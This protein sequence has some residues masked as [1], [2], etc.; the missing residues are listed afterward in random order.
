M[1]K[2]D[3]IMLIMNNAAALGAF[4]KV[5]EYYGEDPEPI[6]VKLGIDP[7]LAENPTSR[8]PYQQIEALWIETL[9]LIDDPYI[10]L[11]V[12]KLWHPST[13]GALGYAWLA[14]PTLRAGFERVVRYLQILTDGWSYHI[15]EQGSEFSLI[16]SCY[17]DSLNIP[18]QMDAHLATLIV[19]CR[20]NYGQNLNPISV[21]FTHTAPK[22]TG[23]YFSFFR[24]PV[25]FNAPDNRIT[26][27]REVVDQH[28]PSSNPLLAQ[29]N[30]QIIQDYLEKIGKASTEARVKTEII[31]QLP[32]GK[33]SDSS[34]A[35]ALSLS[36]RTLHR[37]LQTEQTTFGAIMNTLRQELAQ[38]YI[39]DSHLSLSE[40]SFLL[41]FSEVSSFSRAFKRWT[42]S[43]PSVLRKKALLT[44]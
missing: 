6:F 15:E 11:T 16:H 44:G 4:L 10:G 42:G 8:I 41:G 37:R 14:S 12:A 35:E 2:V 28:L 26:L 38:Q 19:L 29:L 25:T 22:K 3:N 27:A 30:D 39:Q 34:I 20:M 5:I 1:N 9:A 24:C 31:H 33:V 7:Q 36:R 32:S 17:E 18:K 21:S 40:V 13:A 43:A 23:E